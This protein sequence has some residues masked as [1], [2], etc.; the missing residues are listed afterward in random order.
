[1]TNDLLEKAKKEFQVAFSHLEDELKKFR[2]GRASTG[3]LDGVMVEV[4]GSQMP[5]V[6]AGSITV[7]EAQLIQ[8]TPFD[9]GNIQAIAAAIRDNQSL[10]FNPADDGRVI[11]IQVP[12][13]TTER[14]EQLVKQLGEKSEECFIRARNARHE[15][16]NEAKKLKSDG[17]ITQDDEHRLTKQ[18]DDEMASLKKKVEEA[19][20]IK[21]KEILTV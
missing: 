5:L 2:T 1:M 6:A 19:I 14:R 17:K 13:L 15:A 4:Y 9:P 11:R 3:M 18:V 20:A 12:P 16:L 7:P 21:E 8:I 10:G